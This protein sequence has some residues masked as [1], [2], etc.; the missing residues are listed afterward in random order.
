MIQQQCF[1]KNLYNLLFNNTYSCFF[2]SYQPRDCFRLA[3]G[4]KIRSLWQLSV[5]G[6]AELALCPISI[7]QIVF[8]FFIKPINFKAAAILLQKLFLISARKIIIMQMTMCMTSVFAVTFDSSCSSPQLCCIS[9]RDGDK[10]LQRFPFDRISYWKKV[11]HCILWNYRGDVAPFQD[12][13]LAYVF[14][15][16]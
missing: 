12:F 2:W 9:I 3:D 10:V 15:D 1:N 11:K 14:W 7:W 6:V 4:K 16:Y 5:V 8:C 13:Q